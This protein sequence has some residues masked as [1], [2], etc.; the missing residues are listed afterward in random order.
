MRGG[1]SISTSGFGKAVLQSD[2]RS[3]KCQLE[4]EDTQKELC[5]AME[6]AAMAENLETTGTDP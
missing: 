6:N 2:S 4:L 1:N 3:N 5:D